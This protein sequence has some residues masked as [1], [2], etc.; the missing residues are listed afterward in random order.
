LTAEFAAGDVASFAIDGIHSCVMSCQHARWAAL[1]L[2]T[3]CA[4]C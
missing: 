4:I 3:Q 2:I 1:P